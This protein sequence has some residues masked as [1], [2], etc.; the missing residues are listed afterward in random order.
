MG[1]SNLQAEANEPRRVEGGQKLS[2]SFPT[3]F[4]LF[5]PPVFF[6]GGGGRPAPFLLPLTHVV[7]V[8]VFVPDFFSGDSCHI[9]VGTLPAR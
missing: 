6:F 2:V 7:S 3:P 1:Q 9:L 4:R 5:S 8:P